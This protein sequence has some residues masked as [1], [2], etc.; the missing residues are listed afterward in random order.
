MTNG[1][2]I[3]SEAN[4]KFLPEFADSVNELWQSSIFSTIYKEMNTQQSTLSST[5]IKIRTIFNVE[6][7]LFEMSGLFVKAAVELD[8]ATLALGSGGGSFLG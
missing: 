6:Q 2:V 5:F 3:N 8:N 7:L 4:T 1:C